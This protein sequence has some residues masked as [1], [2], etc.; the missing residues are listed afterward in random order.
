MT[1]HRVAL[2]DGDEIAY[3][4]GFLTQDS[5]HILTRPND[6]VNYHFKYKQDAIEWVGDDQ[7]E[8]EFSKLIYP[9][10]KS[11]IKLQLQR[12]MQFIL[13]RTD[14]DTYE[15]YLT[16]D[17]NFRIDLATIRPYKGNRDSSM[18]PYYMADIKSQ[19]ISDY[20]AVVL[21][22]C[23]ADDGIAIA[24]Y[25]YANL[26]KKSILVTQDK[27]LRM[28]PGDYFDLPKNKLG[29]VTPSEGIRWFFKQVLMGDSTDNI[30]GI[31]RM[32][33]V[34][35]SK[36]I[37]ELNTDNELE[38]WLECVNQYEIALKNPKVASKMSNVTMPVRERVI[39][40]AR[41]VWM[42][43][44]AGEIWSPD[45]ETKEEYDSRYLITKQEYLG[46]STKELDK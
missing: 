26:G 5:Y 38:M 24:Q 44:F 11:L 28:V 25:N 13:Q 32:G 46:E 43:R 36:I 22:D 35:A 2:I 39:E 19:M 6:T 1:S 34:K 23:E 17:N 37:D 15:V 14:S 10:N 12:I 18:K 30:E 21:D 4:V 33:K 16:G 40:V 27:D 41:L 8:W 42:Q 31:H 9:R 29:T 20:A 3:K 45:D 7:S